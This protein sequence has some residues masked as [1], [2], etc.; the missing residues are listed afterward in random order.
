[1]VDMV[2]FGGVSLMVEEKQEVSLLWSEQHLQSS[3]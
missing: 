1:M 3:S 2:G